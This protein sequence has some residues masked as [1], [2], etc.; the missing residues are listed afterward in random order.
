MDLRLGSLPGLSFCAKLEWLL[1]CLPRKFRVCARVSFIDLRVVIMV[2][3]VLRGLLGLSLVLVVVC[4]VVILGLRGT[5]AL[6]ETAVLEDSI[7]PEGRQIQTETGAIYIEEAGPASGPALLLVHGSVGWSRIWAEITPALNS[8]GYRTIA[9]DLPPMGYSD[10]DPGEDYGRATQAKRITALAKA[11]GVKPILIAHSFG[12]GPAVEAAM[13]YPDAYQGMVLISAAV[14]L[15]AHLNETDLPAFLRPLAVR[16]LAISATATNFM[17][18]GALVRLFLNRKDMLTL[19]HIETLQQAWWLQGTTRAL[20][21]WV[22]NLLVP[23]RDALSTRPLSYASVAMPVALIWGD[24]DTTT[25]IAQAEALQAALGDAT[26]AVLPDVGHIPQI[27]DPEA[28]RAALV[29]A[30]ASVTA[31]Q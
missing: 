15:D 13:L 3:R 19:A 25:P 26:L 31:G 11:L 5:A 28:L 10:R 18:T 4:V 22:P 23:P 17:A 21:G 30:L 29:V 6:R 8:A 20:A 27:E 14:G 12:A 1:P 7:P 16:Q 24:R 9:M 2:F